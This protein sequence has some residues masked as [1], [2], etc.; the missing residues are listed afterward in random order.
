MEADALDKGIS[1]D[2]MLRADRIWFPPKL[3]YGR[4]SNIWFKSGNWV[5]EYTNDFMWA[6]WK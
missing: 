3:A 2:W 6:V 5:I 1:L 4:Y